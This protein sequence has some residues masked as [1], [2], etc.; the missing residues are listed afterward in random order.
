MTDESWDLGL[1]AAFGESAEPR[2]Q[3]WL[4]AMPPPELRAAGTSPVPLRTD[5]P[6]VAG[7]AAGLGRLQVLGEIAR[8]GGGVV[9]AAH[10]PELGRTLAV[11]VMHREHATDPER[12]RRFV[13]EAQIGGQLQHP[14]IVPVH[15][16]YLDDGRRPYFAM[17]LVQGR[18]LSTLLRER[19]G[20]GR[21]APSLPRHLRASLSD[22]GVRTRSGLWCTAT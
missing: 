19:S 6:E 14:G 18:T 15:G 3:T 16:L 11:K 7:H 10:D 2:D 5:S 21:G 9:L 17:K 4:R 12:V 1:R 20:S 22:R 8:G 13:E